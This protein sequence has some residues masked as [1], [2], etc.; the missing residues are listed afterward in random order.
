MRRF[1]IV[2]V[3]LALALF[4][5]VPGAFAADVMPDP[6]S[7]NPDDTFTFTGTGFD[8]GAQVG[9][10]VVSP[11]GQE[12]ELTQNGQ[13]VIAVA[14]DNGDFALHV[15]PSRDMPAAI[16]GLFLFVFMDMATGEVY[17]SEIDV[18]GPSYIPGEI[19]V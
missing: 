2:L 14:D 18:S 6:E 5:A 1:L 12:F 8:P 10:L 11:D 9:I 19:D 16:G 13:P 3:V 17:M 15:L 4:A 7:G